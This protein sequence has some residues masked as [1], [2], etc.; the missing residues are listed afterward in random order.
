MTDAFLDIRDFGAIAEDPAT[1]GPAI[2]AAISQSQNSG[3]EVIIPPGDWSGNVV[4]TVTS[5][6]TI[7]GVGSPKI[8]GTWA[9]SA[10][11]PTSV[12]PSVLTQDGPYIAID[13]LDFHPD[14]SQSYSL[15]ITETYDNGGFHDATRIS[16]CRF[17]GRLGLN[18]KSLITG[19]MVSNHFYNTSV[20][21]LA[22]S[23][24]N[25]KVWGNH[26]RG[27][28]RAGVIITKDANN[29]A[30]T[31]GEGIQFSQ[32]EFAVCSIGALL[33]RHMWG[34]FDDCL[35]DYCRLPMAV[36]GSKNIKLS[37]S[38]LGAANIGSIASHP[39]FVSPPSEHI[40]LLVRGGNASG[41]LYPSSV[42]AIN[43]DF[44]C[45]NVGS[46]QPLIYADGVIPGHAG[47]F[48]ERMSILG[49]C[50][51]LYTQNH[52][53]PHMACFVNCGSVDVSDAVWVSVNKSTS[54]QDI[55]SVVNASSSRC[56]N[57]NTALVWQGGVQLRPKN[58]ILQTTR[59]VIPNDVL[60]IVN[61]AGEVVAEFSASGADRV[62]LFKG[63][64]LRPA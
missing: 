15:T 11:F 21:W 49:G 2:V 46:T 36:I 3:G 64:Q 63:G 31:G 45:Y 14:D 9:L 34:V 6:L 37:N 28:A 43:T 18:T 51:F 24:S 4:V 54:L 55:F 17:F 39:D 42:T 60:Q 12:A 58:E 62:R 57:N 20:G 8:K 30:R 5:P 56:A 29:P 26:W 53:A 27:A 7:K 22:E 48:V 40:A 41:A 47:K 19:I 50:T 32:C 33:D 23:C 13:G 10:D 44:V 16:N 61:Q 1:H 25:F 52:S 35:F 59:I 38:Y